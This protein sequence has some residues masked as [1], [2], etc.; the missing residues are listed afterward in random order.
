MADSPTIRSLRKLRKEGYFCAVV[1]KW[2]PYVKTRHDLFGFADIIAVLRNDVVLVQT[3]SGAHV[4][5]RVSKILSLQSAALWLDSPNRHIVVHGWAKRGPRGKRKLWDC[6][7][8]NV[9]M[10]P[11]FN[12]NELI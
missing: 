6:R 1:E 12:H 4:A 5:A 2:N 8:I 3:T 10:P 7:V 9:T 11:D